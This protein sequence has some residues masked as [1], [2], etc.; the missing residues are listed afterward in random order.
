MEPWVVRPTC[1]WCKWQQDLATG[2][3]TYKADDCLLEVL[4][5]TFK[6]PS[7]TKLLERCVCRTNQ[8]PNEC[9]N[10]RVWVWCLNISIMGLKLSHVLQ[11]LHP[12]DSCVCG[13][14]QNPNKCINSMV[15]VWCP[16]HKHHGAKVIR[17][18]TASAVYH[19]HQG[20]KC[21]K[22]IMEKLSIPG[23]TYNS[24]PFNLND[25]KRFRKA[26]L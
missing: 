10:S 4:Q 3:S 25:R 22:K 7:N 2:T 17:C 12:L 15:W 13:T 24:H 20:P 21:R 1:S 16:K 11:H 6:T 14:T 23:G 5:P 18:A 8:N 9:I 19:S 26:D